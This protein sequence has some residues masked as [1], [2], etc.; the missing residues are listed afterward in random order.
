MIDDALGLGFPEP[1]Q[2][3]ST[4]P[5]LYDALSIPEDAAE[6]VGP[7]RPV[8]G[9]RPVKDRRDRRDRGERRRRR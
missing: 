5:E 7:A 4:S 6:S 9:S 3:F 1:P 2:W 8:L